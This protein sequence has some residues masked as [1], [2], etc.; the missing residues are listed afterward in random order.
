MDSMT[1][2]ASSSLLTGFQDTHSVSDASCASLGTPPGS[3]YG[4]GCSL[5][6][7]GVP[8]FAAL[9]EPPRCCCAG[10]NSRTCRA[11]ESTRQNRCGAPMASCQEGSRVWG[12]APKV[13][14][15]QR[16]PNGLTRLH[17]SPQSCS[18]SDGARPTTAAPS[19]RC[20]AALSLSLDHD[21]LI[22]CAIVCAPDTAPRPVLDPLQLLPRPMHADSAGSSLTT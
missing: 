10:S 12:V 20:D 17:Y 15:W 18:S 11:A 14:A 2:E 3:P 16:M 4:I 9:S 1:D 19:D 22:R 21:A 5:A 13:H 6:A 8:L 7:R